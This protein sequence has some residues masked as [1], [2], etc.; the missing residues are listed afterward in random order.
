VQEVVRSDEHR[1][2]GQFLSDVSP[3]D[4]K[5]KFGRGIVKIRMPEQQRLFLDS[6]LE[7][8]PMIIQDLEIRNIAMMALLRY[9]ISSCKGDDGLVGG[10]KASILDFSK[11]SAVPRTNDGGIKGELVT[12]V[13]LRLRSVGGANANFK[14]ALEGGGKVV[15]NLVVGIARVEDGELKDVRFSFSGMLLA[16]NP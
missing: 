5:E 8:T 2:T 11:L 12:V 4:K 6:Q 1:G 10:K 15:K 9:F 14:A 7:T 16:F 3:F 13:F